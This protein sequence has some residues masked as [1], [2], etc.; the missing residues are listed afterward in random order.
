[1]LC[2]PTVENSPKSI[3]TGQMANN[4]QG[5]GNQTKLSRFI[6][7]QTTTSQKFRL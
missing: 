1:V 4:E 2:S 7:E 6:T 5:L 3:N